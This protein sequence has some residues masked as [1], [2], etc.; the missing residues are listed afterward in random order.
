M[1]KDFYFEYYLKVLKFLSSD[2]LF[3]RKGNFVFSNIQSTGVKS[4]HSLLSIYFK[5]KDNNYSN[6]IYWWLSKSNDLGMIKVWIFYFSW[7]STCFPIY[8]ISKF[9]SRVIVIYCTFF[10]FLSNLDNSARFCFIFSSLELS[11]ALSLIYTIH[12]SLTCNSQCLMSLNF[13]HFPNN[14][15]DPYKRS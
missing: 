7:F 9:E 12:T 5:G 6:D 14:T 4:K 2:S 1:N 15:C 13:A 8:K 11:R 3:I 10:A